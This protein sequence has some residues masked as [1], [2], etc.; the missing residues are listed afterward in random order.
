MPEGSVDLSVVIPCFD[1]ERRLPESLARAMPYLE[2][3]P[4]TFELILVDD[5]SRDGT[6][7]MMRGLAASD[8]RVRVVGHQPNLGKGRALADGVAVSRGRLVLVSDAD[9]STPIEELDKL[10]ARIAAGAGVAI[11]SRA[12]RDSRVEVSQPI[13]RVLMGKTFNL[14]VQAVLLPGLWDTQCG[15]KLFRGD[16]G[17]R[18]FADLRTN[19]FGYDIEILYRARRQGTRIEEVPV[20]WYNSAPTKVAPLRHSLE[21]F[22]DI[23]RVRLRR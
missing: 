4:R 16:L 19:G 14:M 5:G 7:A 18:L 6:L 3:R 10:E 9:F 11:A 22:A 12:K 20:S 1:E 23:F 21:M 17:R 15:F 2:A 8:P 13:Y